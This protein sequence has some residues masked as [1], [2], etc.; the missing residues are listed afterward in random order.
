VKGR[1]TQALNLLTIVFFALAVLTSLC[2]LYQGDDMFHVEHF[3]HFAQ[4]RMFSGLKSG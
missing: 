4:K 2:S 1:A 3:A